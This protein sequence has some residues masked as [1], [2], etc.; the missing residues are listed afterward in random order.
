[1]SVWS[2]VTGVLVDDL[3]D[4]GPNLLEVDPQALQH[5][6][7]DALAFSHQS[8]E[9]VL[10]ADVVVIEAPRLVNREFDDLLRARGQSD[11][12]DRWLFAAPDDELNRRAHLGQLH[13]HVAQHPSGDAIALAHESKEQVLG[14]DVV[15]VEAV[16]LFLG[17]RQ[18]LAGPF[19][20]FV[21]FVCH[22]GSPSAL[23]PPPGE[24]LYM[25]S[26]PS[27]RIRV[28]PWTYGLAHS[29]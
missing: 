3:H 16:G 10:G 15:M 26:T 19:R 20:K 7:R 23:G 1:M 18:D 4:L 25:V 22:P 12:A 29:P 24:S 21:E 28:V 27:L 6:C 14:A 11:L 2:A 5:A 17:E 8:E 9:Q 13:A